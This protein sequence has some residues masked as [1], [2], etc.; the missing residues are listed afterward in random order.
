MFKHPFPWVIL[1][2]LISSCSS[3][4]QIPATS[5]PPLETPLITAV[6][7]FPVEPTET[8]S[9]TADTLL[10]FQDFESG[11]PAIIANIPKWEVFMEDDGNHILC[12]PEADNFYSA[13][14]GR[15][16]WTDYAVEA[17]IKSMEHGA[18]DEAYVSL[19]ARLEPYTNA[20]Y[21]A[22]VNFDTRLYDLQFNIPYVGYG[23]QELPSLTDGEWY[24]LRVEVVGD[25]IKFYI[26]DELRLEGNGSQRRN[27]A[28]SIVASNGLKICMDNVRA[29]ALDTEGQPMAV[30]L[31]AG[32]PDSSFG[33]YEAVYPTVMAN[34][35]P[36]GLPAYEYKS[37]CSQNY[38]EL[39]T[40]F[41]WNLT[42]VTT[43][44]PSGNVFHLN[45]DFYINPYSGEVTRR[46]VLY[47]PDGSG[48]PENGSYLFSYYIDDQLVL[49]QT[50]DYVFSMVN[51]VTDIQAV[52]TGNQLVVD[53]TPPADM[54]SEKWYKVYVSLNRKI[55]YSQR[56]DWNVNHAEL[57]DLD[58]VPGEKYEIDVDVFGQD[59][60]AGGK[61]LILVW[62]AS[63]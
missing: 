27:G 22:A 11:D 13:A 30:D 20:G 31:Q 61:T 26:N 57:S 33:V 35:N 48:Y 46:W 8:S 24:L 37:N 43:T 47:G 42:D 15:D 60:S 4:P 62:K 32:A 10:F 18:A 29:W 44:T 63:P 40:C 6:P 41:L 5:A 25:S 34:R 9:V 7:T 21:Y 53:W 45:K 54:N 1:F 55:L 3:A 56:F 49:E 51:P 50:L 38:V 59:N 2:I 19:F 28:A 16:A 14:F 23:Q 52:Q 12:N 58:L 39:E 36:D 17:R